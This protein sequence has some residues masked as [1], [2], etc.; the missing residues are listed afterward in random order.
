MSLY[1]YI[2]KVCVCGWITRMWIMKFNSWRLFT[3]RVLHK[4]GH[5]GY[6]AFF[7]RFATW[8]WANKKI[9]MKSENEMIV[10]CKQPIKINT[11]TIIASCLAVL[12]NQ[13]LY[14]FS[15]LVLSTFWKLKWQD[16]VVISIQLYLYLCI[17]FRLNWIQVDFIHIFLCLSFS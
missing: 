4:E 5:F 14:Q 1:I 15:F 2:E 6:W 9:M 3:Q 7:K 8:A 16:F 13:S 11:N 12:V 17:F 10:W